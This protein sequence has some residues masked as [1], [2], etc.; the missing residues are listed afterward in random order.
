MNNKIKFRLDKLHNHNTLLLFLNE[1]LKLNLKFWLSILSFVTATPVGT[2]K[3]TFDYINTS[4][5]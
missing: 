3:Y 1:C 2:F 4:P 5:Q